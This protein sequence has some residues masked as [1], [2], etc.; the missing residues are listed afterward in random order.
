MENTQNTIDDIPIVEKQSGADFSEFEGKR[1]R[2]AKVSQVEV[3]DF[4]PDGENYNKDSKEKVMKLEIETEVIDGLSKPVTARFPLQQDVDKSGNKIWVISKHSKA[5]LWAFMR[6]LN[7]S[8]PSE[9]IN[10]LVT[11]TLEPSKTPGD[12]RKFLRIVM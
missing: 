9:L 3:T 12:N 2:I 7:A 6:K 5:K 8:K 11:L 4:Y 1:V 10:K